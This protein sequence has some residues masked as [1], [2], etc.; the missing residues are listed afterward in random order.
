MKKFLKDLILF[1]WF[2]GKT[3]VVGIPYLWLF[4]CSLVPFFII[5]K[6]SMV[7]MEISN[8]FGSIF[9]YVD[10]VISLKIKISNYL[11]IAEDNLYVLTYLSSIK[12]AAITTLFCLLIGYPFAYFMAR[13]KASIRPTLMMMVML[14]F[15][16][17]FL[18]RI[19]AWK[20][21]LAN[22]G[23]VN[24][25]LLSI[26]VIDA[27]IHM[28]NTPFSLM[29]GMVY[30]YLPFMILPLYT[31]LSKM[32]VRFIEAAADLGSNPWNTFWRVTVPLSKSGII[33][34][35]MLVFIP[36]VGE[37][38]I[39]ELLGGPETLMIGHVLWD[40]FFSNND[41][42]MASAVTV[43][44]ILLILVPMGIFNKYQNN[45]TPEKT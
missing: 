12:F 9:S 6:I 26:G 37:Y 31:N 35:A 45:Q 14:P 34:G 24:H 3:A 33:A 1:K 5:L 17:S 41:W 42:P 28:M 36:C 23:V 16:T 38:V 25:F 39:P 30:T 44:V 27:P 20:G 2:S 22:N 32:D 8:P 21:M 29:V 15:W 11:F 43:V 19:Y 13:A 4:I 10:G 40:E 18:L 7:E